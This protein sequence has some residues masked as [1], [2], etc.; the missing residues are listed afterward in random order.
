M[1]ET[2][3]ELTVGPYPIQGMVTIPADYSDPTRLPVE[4]RSRLG[5]LSEDERTFFAGYTEVNGFCLVI[6][7]EDSR[8]AGCHP[9][10]GSDDHL[11]WCVTDAQ[12]NGLVLQPFG[13][14]VEEFVIGMAVISEEAKGTF[15]P[16]SMRSAGSSLDART[17]FYAADPNPIYSAAHYLV[18]CHESDPRATGMWVGSDDTAAN[19]PAHHHA[20]RV[21]KDNSGWTFTP[22]E[23]DAEPGD[24]VDVDPFDAVEDDTSSLDEPSPDEKVMIGD[25]EIKGMVVLE[26]GILGGYDAPNW[27]SEQRRSEFSE[28]ERT[29]FYTEAT[30]ASGQVRVC[31]VVPETDPRSDGMWQS[32]SYRS[33]VALPTG[34]KGWWLPA[35][36]QGFTLKPFAVEAAETVATE[37]PV[38]YLARLTHNETG[39]VYYN[40]GAD[41]T[42]TPQWTQDLAEAGRTPDKAEAEAWL[43]RLG[44]YSR[45]VYTAEVIEEAVEPETE[46]VDPSP[47]AIGDRV[48]VID[49]EHAERRIGRT[50]VLEDLD[51]G[52]AFE[53][54]AHPFTVVMDSDRLTIYAVQV[55]KVN[56]AEVEEVEAEDTIEEKPLAEGD[57]LRVID[58]A[59]SMH[60]EQGEI[61]TVVEPSNP[62][63][64]RLVM[65]Q[66]SRGRRYQMY[67][68]RFERVV[69]EPQEEHGTETVVLGTDTVVV[70]TGIRVEDAPEPAS[71]E[72]LARLLEK[73]QADLKTAKEYHEADIVT[74]SERLIR[75]AE[76]REW[77]GEYDEIVRSL[78]GDLSVPLR[79]RYQ[80]FTV[81]MTVTVPLTW[82]ARATDADDAQAKAKAWVDERIVRSHTSRWRD[83]VIGEVRELD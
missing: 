43:E 80:E 29:F 48:K 44:R 9:I 67:N 15:G 59:G 3:T 33:E 77:C 71:R 34:Y 76:N 26:S 47:L 60:A 30:R 1:T 69:E 8:S 5:S 6:H 27:F 42:A 11:Y 28:D 14:P 4:L 46:P 10:I 21:E 12:D 51:S 82:R 50:G 83:L 35:D 57:K 45:D 79:K 32:V 72:D 56:T 20:W 19:L 22:F 13:T 63:D 41:R 2:I 53:G 25:V 23:S 16:L 55:E 36:G 24:V 81:D 49:A 39:D 78:N 75:E 38:V 70:G 73:A 58:P 74:I 31:L 66:N 62:V 7:A 68:H 54:R 64:P 17:Y 18:V 37:T 61:V 52:R 65:V 40:R